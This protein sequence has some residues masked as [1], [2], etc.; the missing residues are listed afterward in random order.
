MVRIIKIVAPISKLVSRL[1]Q[2]WFSI[3]IGIHFSCCDVARFSFVT[4]SY[5][6]AHFSIN[7]CTTTACVLPICC[8]SISIFNSTLHTFSCCDF[9]SVS[10]VTRTY[11]SAHFAFN[12][13]TGNARRPFLCYLHVVIRLTF[14]IGCG[15]HVLAVTLHYF[16]VLAL[17]TSSSATVGDLPTVNSR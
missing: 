7:K 17:P 4:R 10:S 8:N 11:R 1:S 5:Q 16:P 12:K 6:A 14:T 9:P 3:G 2:L 13:R 15:I